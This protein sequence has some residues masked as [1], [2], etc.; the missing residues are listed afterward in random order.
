[1]V[2]VLRCRR[3]HL[4]EAVRAMY[5]EVASSP[6]KVF[7]FPTGRPACVFVGYPESEL[8]R[9]PATAL[10]SFAGV[11][12]PFLADAIGRDDVALDVGSGSG[13]DA[14]IASL[15]VGPGGKVYALD[16]TQP[17]LDKL[18]ERAR[19]MGAADVE[20]LAGNAEDI[21]LP[22]SCATC[23]QQWCA[24]SRSRQAQRFQRDI[25]RACARRAL[26]V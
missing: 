5:T 9:I 6:G 25:S 10:E 11:G 17:M 23:N 8:N 26:P 7:H 19:K 16:V 1:M 4:L 21:P 13:T 24:Q 22:D 12:Y 14:L 20:A 18:R 15:R 2:A 3:D